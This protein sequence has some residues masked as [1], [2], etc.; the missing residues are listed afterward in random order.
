MRFAMRR[1]ILPILAVALLGGAAPSRAVEPPPL[2]KSGLMDPGPPSVAKTVAKLP[3]SETADAPSAIRKDHFAEDVCAIIA[4]EAARRKLPAQFFAKLIWRES[5]FD[6]GAVSP[7]GAEGIAQFMP[8]TAKERGLKDP[9]SPE[10][11]LPA[12][13]H[14]LADHRAALGNLGLAA[15]AYNAGFQAVLDWLADKRSLPYETQ[16]YVAF[17]TGRSVDDWKEPSSDHE[18]SPLSDSG[19]FQADCR[20]LVKRQSAPPSGPRIAVARAK[21]QPWGVVLSGGFSEGRALKAFGVIKGRYGA[22]LAG[23]KPMVVR[24]KN[25]MGRRKL[26]NVMVGYDNRG[27]A[28]ALCGKL[29][30]LGAACMVIKND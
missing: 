26:V 13:A 25:A 23:K 4:A 10:E 14:L 30:N 5:L 11:A 1:M 27:A 18:I 6:A 22:L 7:V 21:W 20:K 17:I 15:A 24:R 28:D 3:A 2:R 29:Q 16:D 8:F 19:D 9:F 12:S